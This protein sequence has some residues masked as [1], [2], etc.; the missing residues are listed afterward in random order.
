MQASTVHTECSAE[1]S[2][3]Y[4]CARRRA[5]YR[6]GTE[7]VRRWA[8]LHKKRPLKSACREIILPLLGP[9]SGEFAS[10]A[11]RY[12][13]Q[14]RVSIAEQHQTQSAVVKVWAS[15]RLVN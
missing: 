7:V 2:G 6:E 9:E 4:A 15:G 11:L 1:T 14:L 5:H 13:T 12:S 8:V 10:V 3:L